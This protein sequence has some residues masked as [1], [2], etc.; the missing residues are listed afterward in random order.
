MSLLSEK[1]ATVLDFQD[2]NDSSIHLGTNSVVLP[3]V[4][5]FTLQGLCSPSAFNTNYLLLDA[6]GGQLDLQDVIVLSLEISSEPDVSVSSPNPAL[7][8][9]IG[10]T[11]NLGAFVNYSPGATNM[12]LAQVNN[13]Q[14]VNVVNGKSGAGVSYVNNENYPVP[15]LRVSPGPGTITSGIISVIFYC[16]SFF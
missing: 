6:K 16:A 10:L 3:G 9:V 12:T 8:S 15:G 1:V 11:A 4:N 14:Y 13:K 7:F 5:Y 2:V